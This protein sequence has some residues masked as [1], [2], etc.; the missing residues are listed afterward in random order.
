L[1]FFHE[2]N[3]N[4]FLK[5]NQSLVYKKRGIF[6]G[7]LFAVRGKKIRMEKKKEKWRGKNLTE[8]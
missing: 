3:S 6:F 1:R 2:S 8:W 4:S 7:W 5:N